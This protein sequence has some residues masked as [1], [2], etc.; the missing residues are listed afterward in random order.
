MIF[1]RASLRNV[2]HDAALRNKV[3]L[4]RSGVHQSRE[5]DVGP[6]AVRDAARSSL[7]RGCC[8]GVTDR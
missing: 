7:D 4:V 3:R 1:L 8:E 6:A 2:V 5:I